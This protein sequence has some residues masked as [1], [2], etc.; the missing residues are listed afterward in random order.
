MHWLKWELKICCAKQI[1]CY[2][3]IHIRMSLY[4]I[5]LRYLILKTANRKK[6]TTWAISPYFLQSTPYSRTSQ[7]LQNLLKISFWDRCYIVFS[8]ILTSVT[9]LKSSFQLR[10]SPE[11]KTRIQR[12]TNLYR[13]EKGLSDMGVVCYFTNSQESISSR[14]CCNV[15]LQ[16]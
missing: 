5:F 10:F 2:W 7:N 3:N 8:L 15:S 9:R 11:G 13:K 14:T 6:S 1:P 16:Q 12:N 4:T